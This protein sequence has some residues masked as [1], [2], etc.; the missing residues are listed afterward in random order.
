MNDIPQQSLPEKM[1][2]LKVSYITQLK[3]RQAI[4]ERLL[5]ACSQNTLSLEERT[6]LKS[7]AHKL[8]GTGTTYGF[9]DISEHGRTLEDALIDQPDALAQ[10]FVA[11]TQSL[12]DACNAAIASQPKPATVFGRK[13]TFSEAE[14]AALPLLLIVDDDENIRNLLSGLF[15]NDARILT[16]TNTEETLSLMNQY[17]PD[18]VLLDDMM[19]GG[20][21]GLRMLEDRH[22]MPEIKDIPVIMI[23]ASDKPEEVMRGLMAGA[24]DYITKPFNP[25]TIAPKIKGLL[26]R[27]HNKILIADDDEAVRELLKHKFQ[28]AGCKVVLASDGA[29]AWTALQKHDIALALLDRMMPGFDGITLLRLIKDDSALTNI[30]VIFLTARHYG[31]DVLEGLNTGAADYI[32]KPFNPDEVVMRCLRLLK[33]T[34]KLES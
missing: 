13:K 32:T 2:A 24:T 26:K 12:L 8:A 7:Q 34:A 9:P 29:E 22:S 19:P 30:P 6:E 18:L 4:L 10:S 23:T 20:I 21:S 33:S 31:A 5:A 16:G 14:T 1:Q 27:L 17:M 11:L 25:E 28:N 3:E 15:S